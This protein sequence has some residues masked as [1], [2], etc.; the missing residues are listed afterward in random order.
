LPGDTVREDAKAFI[1]VNGKKLSEPYIEQRRRE[2]DAAD[3]DSTW[4]VP[5]GQYFFMG[6]NRGN[7]CDSRRWGPVPRKNL[8]G[9]VFLTYWPPQRVS[10]HAAVPLLR[11]ALAFRVGPPGL[12]L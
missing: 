1:W 12:F 7:S 2:Q 11:R 5:K 8:I 9:P 6:D 10:L 3:R 4:H